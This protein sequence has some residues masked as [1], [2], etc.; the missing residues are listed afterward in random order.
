[1]SAA[2]NT[3]IECILEIAKKGAY[4]EEILKSIHEQDGDLPEEEILRFINKLIDSQILVSQLDP[5]PLNLGL[6]S[7]FKGIVRDFA[8]NDIKSQITTLC[9]T[10]DA[11]NGESP[12]NISGKLREASESRPV[13]IFGS[14]GI[15]N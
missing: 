14:A 12:N 7:T 13:A 8:D 15:D 6:A 11:I 4:I 9:D 5:S 10:V 2:S 3:A 1:V